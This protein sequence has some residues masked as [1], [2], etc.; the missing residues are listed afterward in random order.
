ML[1]LPDIAAT[2]ALEGNF[3][4]AVIIP[5][6]LPYGINPNI[7]SASASLASFGEAKPYAA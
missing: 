3:L 7:Q 1:F 2:E 5:S 6:H 4:E